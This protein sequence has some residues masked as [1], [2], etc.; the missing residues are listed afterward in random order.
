MANELTVD[1]NLVNQAYRGM[2][3]NANDEV[4]QLRAA[5]TQ[6]QTQVN[7]LTS[8]NRELKTRNN[9]L[10]AESGRQDGVPEV[11]GVAD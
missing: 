6:L 3:A 9:Q 5:A 4:A 2:L 7:E 10:M 11:E 8:E 1:P